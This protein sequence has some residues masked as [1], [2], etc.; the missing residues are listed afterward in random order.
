MIAHGSA[1]ITKDMDIC[2]NRTPANLAA[3]VAAF[4]G[5]HPY[6][7]GVPLG[8]PFR[9]DVPT[10]HAGLNFTLVTDLGD[11]DLLGEVSGV[12][13]YEQ[14]LAQSVE[15]V[16]FGYTVRILSIESLIAAKKAAGRIKDRLH[17]LELEE[18]RKLRDAAP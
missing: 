1:Y 15:K 17:V 18:L 8:L 13:G 7:R 2:Y 6:L 4:A 11:I 12:G 5:I 14:A 3:I 16:V 9:F 10:M